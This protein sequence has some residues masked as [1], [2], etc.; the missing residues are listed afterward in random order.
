MFILYHAT[1]KIVSL[2][3]HLKSTVNDPVEE[4]VDIGGN[5]LPV[6]SY[7]PVEIKKDTAHQINECTNV[8]VPTGNSGWSFKLYT[9]IVCD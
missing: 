4:E 7:P 5:E 9:I 3:A 1:F 6:S 8:G 2:T